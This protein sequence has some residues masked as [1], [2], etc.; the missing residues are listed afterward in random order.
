MMTWLWPIHTGRTFF[1]VW[2]LV[3]LT[4]WFFAGSIF[5]SREYHQKLSGLSQGLDLRGMN[6]GYC[7]VMAF[8]WEVFERFAE[9]Q[10]PQYWLSPESWYNSWVSDPLMCA[11]AVLACWY[12]LDHWRAK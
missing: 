8:G 7:L 4:F 3:H 5:W 2:S 9:K 1:D 6:F 11:V 12:A 10:W